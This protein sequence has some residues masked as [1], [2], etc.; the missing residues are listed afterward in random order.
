LELQLPV[1]GAKTKQSACWQNHSDL[2]ELLLHNQ[3]S[4]PRRED[5]FA[6][7]RV[8]EREEEGIT[9][10]TRLHSKLSEPRFKL[11]D[12]SGESFIWD[13]VVVAINS[14]D[15]HSSLEI[16]DQRNVERNPVL[17]IVVYSD[18][19]LLRVDWLVLSLAICRVFLK[20]EIRLS[21]KSLVEF[22]LVCHGGVVQ[23]AVKEPDVFGNR[24]T[25]KFERVVLLEAKRIRG[26]WCWWRWWHWAILV[27]LKDD[28]QH[29]NEHQE[30][31]TDDGAD[32][33]A[34]LQE[35]VCVLMSLTSMI[36]KRLLFLF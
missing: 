24:A 11:L 30:T 21:K 31:D 7:E 36:N 4:L 26:I 2:R 27:L 17:Y 12:A 33:S 15:L 29:H 16:I 13:S 5:L 3:L 14:T 35:T 6:I 1:T 28:D 25:I 18:W 19:N 34:L 20:S 10:P 8:L 9:I 23:D 22:A 32:D